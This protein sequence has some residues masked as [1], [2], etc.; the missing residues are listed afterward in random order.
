MLNLAGLRAALIVAVRLRCVVVVAGF[1][2]P[3]ADG[4]RVKRPVRNVDAAHAIDE[5]PIF[6]L[7]WCQPL[8]GIPSANLLANLALADFEW[9][10]TLRP[11]G[12]FDFGVI[13]ERWRSAKLAILAD[14]LGIEH[15][16]RLAALTLHGSFLGQPAARLVG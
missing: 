15:R 8:A 3:G 5:R 4:L 1:R 9:Q 2:L 6:Q 16:N 11:D 10:Q 12:R 13:N 14:P 7:P